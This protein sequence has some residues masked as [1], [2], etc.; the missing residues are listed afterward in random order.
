MADTQPDTPPETE[1]R[2]TAPSGA[3]ADDPEGDATPPNT[4]RVPIAGDPGPFGGAEWAEVAADTASHWD[5][6]LWRQ[7]PP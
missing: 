5:S 7:S 3:N 2:P 4:V 1:R 6:G